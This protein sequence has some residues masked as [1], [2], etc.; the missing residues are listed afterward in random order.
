MV[1]L[2]FRLTSTDKF[3]KTH[4]N[5]RKRV[6]MKQLSLVLVLAVS[7]TACKTNKKYNADVAA[8]KDAGYASGMSDGEAKAIKAAN[9]LAS[10]QAG[11][12]GSST[13]TMVKFGKDNANY[14]VIQYG[15]TY[16]AVDI[17]QYTTGTSA[18]TYIY[19]GVGVYDHLTANADGTFS[20]NAGTCN[21]VA[22]PT[23][24]TMVFEKTSGSAKD[25]DKAAALAES[26]QVEQTAAN[27]SAEFGL[28]E[29]RSLKVAKLAASWEKL[30]KSRALTNADADAF[31]YELTGVSID[32]MENAEKAMMSGSMTELNSVIAKAAEVNGTSSENMSAIMMKLFF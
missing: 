6:K 14:I 13:Y 24:S 29:E 31:S 9:F 23:S 3:V 15:T 21:G 10:L 11:A 25:M 8:A 18:F 1:G 7:L 16:A 4:A 28:S 5:L 30:S 20:C 19:S 27:L 22:G 2:S 12:G 26:F 32:D 17:S